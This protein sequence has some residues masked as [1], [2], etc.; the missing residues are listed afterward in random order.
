MSTLR[1]AADRWTNKFFKVLTICSQCPCH[2]LP[3]F[4][5]VCRR[6]GKLVG[7]KLA[8][9]HAEPRRPGVDRV[10]LVFVFVITNRYNLSHQQRSPRVNSYRASGST[11]LARLT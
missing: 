5:G 10:W 9:W 4:H 3:V 8:P 2:L 7:R 11:S 6:P 1:S